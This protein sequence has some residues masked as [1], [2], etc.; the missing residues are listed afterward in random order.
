MKKKIGFLLLIMVFFLA[1]PV[2]AKGSF[3]AGE[4]VSVEEDTD[5]TT[6]V[7]G[8]TIDVKANV[9]GMNF[10]AGNVINL[11]STQD[12]LFVAGN[13]ITITNAS[14]KDMFIAGDTITIRETEVR[15]LYAAGDMITIDSKIARNAYLGGDKII[16]NSEIDGDVVISSDNIVLGENAIINGTLKYPEGVKVNKSDNA[17]VNKMKS[18]KSEEFNIEL[19][20]ADKYIVPTMISYISMLLIA[21]L[22]LTVCKKKFETVAKMSKK[23]IDMLKTVGI[24]LLGLIVIPVAAFIL[25]LTL[26][27]IPL[28]FIA[29]IIY[30]IL[31]YLSIIPTAYYFGNWLLEKNIKNNYLVL[32]LSLLALYILK[33]IPI[34]GGFVELAIICFGLGT[35]LFLIKDSVKV[36]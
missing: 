15:D 30:G 12:Y 31:L 23:P 5:S 20:F 2:M 21:F 25:M 1:T 35:Y 14:A 27:G 36:K 32:T 28:S 29:L 13:N 17:S 22:L 3:Y 10:V 16:I 19:S 24:G 11:S 26:I 8:N 33:V 18:Y 6:F 9:E 34:I 7:A 4:S